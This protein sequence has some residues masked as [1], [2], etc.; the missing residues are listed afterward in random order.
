MKPWTPRPYQSIATDFMYRTPRCN[1]W[2]SPGMG[3]TGSVLALADLLKLTGEWNGPMLVLG[4]KRVARDVWPAEAKK[5]DAFQH[6]RVSPM[7]GNPEMRG[8]ALGTRADI[9]TINY[10]NIVWLM[11]RLG[12]NWPFKIVVADESTRLKSFRAAQGG[13]RTRAL[14]PIA[15][16]A[17]RWINLTGT[18]APNGLQDVWGQQWW[19]D[20]GQRLHR[21]YTAFQQ[22]W[23]QRNWTGFGVTPLAFADGE[24][25]A[26]LKDCTLTLEARDWFD[27]KEPVVTR[28]EV[29]MPAPARAAYK[30]MENTLFTQLESGEEVE[31]FNAASVSGKCLQIACGAVYT[32]HPNWTAVH[33]AKLE[34]LD[35]IAE[36]LNGAPFLV[37]Y[38]W[39]FDKHRILAARKDAVDIS[40]SK[41]YGLFMCG[42]ARIGVAHPGSMGHGVDGLQRIT[43]ILVR[44]GHSW[45]YEYNA[46]MLERIGPTRQIQAGFDRPVL[47]YDIVTKNTLEEAVISR[48]DGKRTV[49]DSLRAYMKETRS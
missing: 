34:A 27:L 13:K 36:E 41:G 29:D 33:D 12:S 46:Q 39:A 30:D 8:R 7:I 18:P 14:S 31:A 23:F 15:H 28:I 40:T 1:L 11:E 9:Y 44:Y 48:V 21:T 38:E 24:I 26:K 49:E 16:K 3:K 5:W 32:D 37:S 47:I 6:L 10:D 17:E 42:K 22:H 20:G 35:S 19:I 45:N 25:K 2:A 4:P 43:H